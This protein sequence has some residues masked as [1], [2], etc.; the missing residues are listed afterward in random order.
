[1]V[2]KLVFRNWIVKVE[3]NIK[4]VLK[5]IDCSYGG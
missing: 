5:E 4:I 2:L 3:D 1:M